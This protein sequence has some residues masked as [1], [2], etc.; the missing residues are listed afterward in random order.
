MNFVVDEPVVLGYCIGRTRVV[1]F[2]MSALLVCFVYFC[3]SSDC[4]DLQ[5]TEQD[6]RKHLAKTS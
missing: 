3:W 6:H 4:R 5:A 1:A 2:V